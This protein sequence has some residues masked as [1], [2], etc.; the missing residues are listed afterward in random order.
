[1]NE[2]AISAVRAASPNLKNA[3]IGCLSVDKSSKNLTVNVITDKAFA[4]EDV[5]KVKAALKPFVP[6][7][8]GFSVNITKL[9][10]DEG[11]VKRKIF[12]AVEKN[13]K[14]IAATLSDGDVEV[15]RRDGGFKFTVAVPEGLINQGKEISARI[16]EYLKRCFCG[17]FYGECVHG[18]S[19]ADMEIEERQDEVEFEVPVR[20]FPIADF[21]F[22]EGTVKRDKATY[23]ADLNFTAGEVVICGQIIE[24]NERTYTNKNG[25]E[26]S[27]F[28]LT[29]GDPSGSTYATYFVRKKSYDKIKQLKAGDS[30]V[31]TGL[32]EEYKGNLRYTVNT[33]DFGRMDPGHVLEKR[34]SKPVPKYYHVVR[35]QPYFDAE[36]TD[37]FT[38]KSIPDCI[39]NNT[40]V[41]FDLETTGLNSSPVSGNMDKIIEIGAYKITGGE[42]CESFFTFINPQRKISEEITRLTG[43]TDEMVKDAPVCEKVMPDFFKFCSGCILVGHNIAQFDFKFVDYYCA[44]EGYILERKLIDTI[45]LSQELLALSNYKLNT[46]ADRFNITFNHHRATDDALAT[47]KVFIEL[48][49]LKKSLPR[50]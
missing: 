22:L 10:P 44:K 50:L 30:I 19:A 38:K 13:F 15:L 25:I 37:L 47:A 49:K 45:P 16:A 39:K 4:E 36:Q 18:R 7:Y 9:S 3:I 40:F 46:V 48:I 29:V 14:A 11:M 41:V 21:R 6:E 28:S 23:I 27:Y 33:I 32:N 43:I 5:I 17:E 12:E 20:R 31:C 1:M 8:F 2:S 35:P 26:R 24:I 34:A 42:I